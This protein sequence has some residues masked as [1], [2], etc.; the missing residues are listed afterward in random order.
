MAVFER[1]DSEGRGLLTDSLDKSYSL[2]S[3]KSIK[4]HPEITEYGWNVTQF[5][6]IYCWESAFHER[7]SSAEKD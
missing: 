2:H 1:Q 3:A 4:F 6:A 5:Y 7:A